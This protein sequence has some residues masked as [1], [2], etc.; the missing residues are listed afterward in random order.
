M[1]TDLLNRLFGSDPTPLPELDG[2]HALAGLLVRTAKTDG[3]YQVEEIRRID[4][5]LAA[6]YGL[7]P[8]EA[9]KLRAESERLEAQAPEDGRFASAVCERLDREHREAV[10]TAMWRVA[11]ADGVEKLEEEAYLNR[12]GER[13]GL[14]EDATLRARKAAE[15]ADPLNY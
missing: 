13:L 14:D 3:F 9:A 1:F 8:V 10:L 2:R 7:N 12:A 11:L 6:T 15:T 4:R 5:I